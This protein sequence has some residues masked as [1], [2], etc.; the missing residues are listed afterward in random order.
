MIL[1]CEVP[2]MSGYISNG[3]SIDT[4][5][6]SIYSQL[7]DKEEAEGKVSVVVSCFLLLETH[8]RPQLQNW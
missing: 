8:K 1:I 7:E 2:P 6:S 5:I 3:F 4:T